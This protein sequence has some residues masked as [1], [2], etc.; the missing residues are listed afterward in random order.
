MIIIGLTLAPFTLAGEPAGK[1]PLRVSNPAG[2]Q[3]G[4]NDPDCKDD[5][6]QLCDH[7]ACRSAAPHLGPLLGE[8]AVLTFVFGRSLED[9]FATYWFL[10][11]ILG[12]LGSSDLRAA[13]SGSSFSSAV[14]KEAKTIQRIGI[15]IAQ[16]VGT[17][18]GNPDRPP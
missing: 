10:P 2:V 1:D 3:R 18:H 6:S 8:L 5:R 11:G 16:T 15:A 13:A 9:T 14:G 4:R 12:L 17:P 7:R